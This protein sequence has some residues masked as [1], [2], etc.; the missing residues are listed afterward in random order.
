MSEPTLPPI[1]TAEASDETA[2]PHLRAVA[3]MAQDGP[4]K[5]WTVT[6]RSMDEARAK[7]AAFWL[8]CEAERPR[9]PPKPKAA[10]EAPAELESEDV[11][12]VI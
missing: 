8:K 7:L 3:W 11:G 4:G 6:A 5:H 2:P 9:K 10:A 1:Y 12:D